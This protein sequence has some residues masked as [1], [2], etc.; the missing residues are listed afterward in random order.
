MK[1][2]WAHKEN[3]PEGR[4]YGQFTLAHFLWIALTVL[5]TV[6]VTIFYNSLDQMNR[7]VVLRTIAATLIISDVIKLLVMHASGIDYRNYLPLEV[8]SFAAYFIVCDSICPDNFIIPQMLLTL[9][10]PAAI[11]AVLFPTTSTL[12]SFNFY[13]IHQFL[14]HGLI[15][16]YVAARFFA[17]EI[18]LI[19]AGLWISVLI[20]RALAAVMYVIDMKYDKNYMF[21]HDAYG[22]P[23][24]ELIY[25]K[26]KDN[27][28]YINGLTF[29]SIAVMHVFYLIFRLIEILI[30]K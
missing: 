9:F 21:L 24:L 23:M 13:T 5:C 12:P 22:N 16:I 19:Y 29:F 26:S 10:L 11:M 25:E 28:G 18:P 6:Y 3:I 1:D 7:L 8:C 27:I 4:G 17:S 14:F 20:V 2:F 15:I 30:L